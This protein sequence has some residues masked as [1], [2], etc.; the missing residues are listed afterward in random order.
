MNVVKG[1]RST[2]EV[3]K[4]TV[5]R[6]QMLEQ[7]FLQGWKVVPSDG[8]TEK[9]I[10]YRIARNLDIARKIRS[11]EEKKAKELEASF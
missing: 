9:I 10:L 8:I 11:I 4:V 1:F 2:R 7:D 3:A 5:Y 6:R